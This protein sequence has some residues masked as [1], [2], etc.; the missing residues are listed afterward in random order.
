MMPVKIVSSTLYLMMYWLSQQLARDHH[1]LDLI[2]AFEDLRQLGV[3]H[4]ALD[5]IIHGVA[6]TAEDLDGV[7]RHLHRHVAADAFGHAG[8]HVEALPV[9]GVAGPRAFIDEGARRLDLHR[10]VRE[11]ELHALEFRD[12][13]FELFA[14]LGV[15]DTCVKRALRQSDRLG[16][17]R[18]TVE[19]EGTHRGAE[20]LALFA[21]EVFQ[22]NTHIVEED[23]RVRRAAEAHLA[24]VTPERD[25][26]HRLRF[27]DEGA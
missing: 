21:N 14:L 26:R 18:R 16:A 4:H 19:I 1:A 20:A 6:V 27:D 15:G 17:D 8:E 7:R 2:G 24:L 9:S 5:R 13:L 10:H 22:G 23:R 25:A 3:A 12:R 11:H